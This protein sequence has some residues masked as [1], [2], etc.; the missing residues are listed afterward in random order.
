M[1]MN[2]LRH[3]FQT[4]KQAHTTLVHRTITVNLLHRRVVAAASSSAVFSH[5]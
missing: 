4:L 2:C 3:P 5:T 1:Q